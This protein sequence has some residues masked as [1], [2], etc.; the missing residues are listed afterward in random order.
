[1]KRQK[2]GNIIGIL[3]AL[4]WIYIGSTKMFASNTANMAMLIL[5]IIG[6]LLNLYLLIRRK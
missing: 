6:G 2:T 4:L 5:G 3:A 1:M